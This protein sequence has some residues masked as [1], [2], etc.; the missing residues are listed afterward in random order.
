M[1]PMLALAFFLH[2]SSL[3]F[4]NSLSKSPRSSI[5][6]RQTALSP[7]ANSDMSLDSSTSDADNIYGTPPSLPSSSSA[8]LTRGLLNLGAPTHSAQSNAVYSP[9]ATNE[10]RVEE[11]V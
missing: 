1:L 9:M 3:E 11:E 2:T 4:I 10:D 7:Y 6:Q 8:S 5:V